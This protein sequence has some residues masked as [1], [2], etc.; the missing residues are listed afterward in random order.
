MSHVE[1]EST[2]L[3]RLISRPREDGAYSAFEQELKIFIKSAEDE[4]PEESY[5]RQFAE[6]VQMS[7]PGNL[8]FD[9]H[10]SNERFSSLIG[11]DTNP[12]EGLPKILDVTPS[13]EIDLFIQRVKKNLFR[14]VTLEHTTDGQDTFT[15][16][17]RG[18]DRLNRIGDSVSI[19]L[20][21]TELNVSA[22]RISPV[23]IN[24]LGGETSYWPPEESNH[25][26]MNVFQCLQSSHMEKYYPPAPFVLLAIA[27]YLLLIP[28]N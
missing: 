10:L 11:T 13:N 6:S 24:H 1:L 21:S 28:K 22:V 7:F 3:F 14:L 5:P 12:I 20:E 26:R 4:F 2:T 27:S 9:S 16:Q 15:V 19:L 23:K 25:M 18:L 17:L 8:F